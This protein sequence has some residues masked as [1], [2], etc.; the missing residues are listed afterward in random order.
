MPGPVETI[1]IGAGSR[2]RDTYGAYAL[3]HPE[4]IRFVAVAEPHPVRRARFA[5]AHGIAP[6]RQFETWQDLI[7]A[8]RTAQAAVIAT[9]DATHVDPAVAA[10]RIGYDVLLE[11][12]M[13]DTLAGCVRLVRVAE[14]TGRLLQISHG[15]RY[16]PFFSTVHDLLAR[17]KLGQ[18]VAVEHRENVSYWHMAHSYVRGNWRNRASAGPMIL[19]KCCHDLDLLYWF[20]GP[21][22]RISS[23]GALVH[24]RSENAPPGA[25]PRCTDGCPHADSCPWYAPRLYLDL[26][27]LLQVA[28]GSQ[29][30]TER[31]GATVALD[32]P[33]LTRLLRR[34]LPAVDALLDYRGWP[35]SV[36]SEDT[37]PCTRRQALET[38]PYGRCVYHCDNDVVDQQVVSMAFPH[39]VSAALVMDGHS[40]E[41]ERTLRIDGSRATLRGRYTLNRQEI[42]LHDHRTGRV[43]RIGVRQPVRDA[44]GHGGG[45]AGLIRAFLAAVHTRSP[46]PTTARASLES[47]LMAFAADEARLEHSV[48]DM[49]GYRQRAERVAAYQG[50]REAE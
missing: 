41:E 5:E 21:C 48:I 29:N 22:E 24:Y 42:E 11:K 31:L 50:G 28:R 19:T 30:L 17:G 4:Q 43:Q 23:T 32:H 2:G 1:L 10:L 6:A 34:L 47:H 15:L 3:A 36:L 16:T 33:T 27:P 12:P 14:S 13:A 26:V 38:G 44:A 40:Y 25:P 39:D 20:L 37:S 9:Q 46:S 35:I 18:V 8:G 45:D 49:E 7:G